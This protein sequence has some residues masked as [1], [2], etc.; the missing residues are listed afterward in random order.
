[1]SWEKFVLLNLSI[2]LLSLGS[3]L[4]NYFLI[5]R[6]KFRKIKE[7]MREINEEIKNAKKQGDMEKLNLY[8]K[9]SVEKTSE[10]LLLQRKPLLISFL[11]FPLIFLFLL[12]YFSGYIIPFPY[13]YLFSFLSFLGF[14][15]KGVSWF[16]YFLILSLILSL[17]FR[18]LLKL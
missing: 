18:K 12:Q 8:L 10:M 7:E 1:M 14:S 2:F 5:D 15:E 11:L 16:T 17:I 3:A 9:K 13:A 6:E 4:I